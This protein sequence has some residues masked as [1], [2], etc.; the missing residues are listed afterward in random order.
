MGNPEIGYSVGWEIEKSRFPTF[1][2]WGVGKI[3]NPDTQVENA[4]DEK[5]AARLLGVR[6]QHAGAWLHALPISSLGLKLSGSELRVICAARLGLPSC[7]PHL[8]QDCGDEVANDGVHG[9]SCRKSR[10]S[11]A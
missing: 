10:G 1:G 9:L 11:D 8:C 7:Q 3:K 5:T 2:K 6:G 4:M